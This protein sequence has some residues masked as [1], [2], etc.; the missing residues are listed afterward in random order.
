MINQS[1]TIA[2]KIICSMVIISLLY[3]L[4]EMSTIKQQWWTYS[5][6]ILIAVFIIVSIILLISGKIIKD[7]KKDKDILD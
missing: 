3:L 7:Y 5:V 2:L 4:S 1:R 6:V